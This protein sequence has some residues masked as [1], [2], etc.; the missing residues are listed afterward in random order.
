MR[1]MFFRCPL[2]KRTVC[3][4]HLMVS[5][6]F[7]YGTARAQIK[8][9]RVYTSPREKPREKPRE[10]PREKPREKPREE[11]REKPREKPTQEPRKQP[12]GEAGKT[13]GEGSSTQAEGKSDSSGGSSDDESKDASSNP[14]G[15]GG[16]PQPKD[17]GGSKADADKKP[18]QSSGKDEK[19]LKPWE[20]DPVKKYGT[21]KPW[22]EDGK[23]RNIQVEPRKGKN[24]PAKGEK[25]QEKARKTKP[26]KVLKVYK[27]RAFGTTKTDPDTLLAIADIKVGTV[28]TAELIEDTRKRIINSKLFRKVT[29]FYEELPQKKGWA[30]LFIEAKDRHSWFIAPMFQWQDGRWGGAVAYGEC[31]LFG[32]G[33]RLG[34]AARYLN[35]SQGLGLVYDDP[36]TF[37]TNLAFRVGLGFQRKELN[38]YPRIM[39]PVLSR[40]LPA[41]SLWIQQLFGSLGFGYRF[42]R[43][44]EM[45]ANYEFGM[46]AFTK[47]QCFH[48]D[49]ESGMSDECASAADE[50]KGAYSSP[51]AFEKSDGDWRG[52]SAGGWKFWDWKRETRLR[53]KIDFNNVIDIYGVKQGYQAKF[54][55]DLSHPHLGSEFQ[56][57]K[58]MLY[59]KK[60]FSVYKTHFLDITVKHEQ[61]Y[62]APY[63][64]ELFMGGRLLPG[65]TH[66]LALGDMNTSLMVTYNLPLFRVWWFDFRQVF[67]YRNAWIFFRK[68]GNEEP[69]FVESNG[70]RRYHLAH[71]PGPTDRA[72]F[73]QAIGTG[74]RLYVK[75]VAIPLLG[76]DVGYGLE[77]N[78]VRFYFYVGKAY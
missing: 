27:V 18:S 17:T 51:I 28:I 62:N 35:D 13:E 42:F 8:S 66:R 31:N 29:V 26:E 12:G 54:Q 21:I 49:P 10:E 67:Y 6:I 43:K 20:D 68:G 25:E 55:L 73:L 70:V 50:F 23:A 11:P 57:V 37:G 1:F 46:V 77:S 76:V 69:Y 59:G 9:T 61:A 40:S 45:R 44:L 65:Y 48:S 41:R 4:I 3:L 19:K 56:Y 63:H 38:E 7:G 71:T 53:L 58:L 34:G 32:W 22:G 16:R 60:I 33:K 30:Y 75:A 24:T 64:R 5:L 14:E 52:Q 78:D 74:L 47:P 72:S 15:A 39:G 36:K 2:Y